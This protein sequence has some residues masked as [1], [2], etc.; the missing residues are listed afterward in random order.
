MS[1]S[2]NMLQLLSTLLMV[3]G[4]ITCAMSGIFNRSTIPMPQELLVRFMAMRDGTA[5]CIA[6]SLCSL[7]AR[8]NEPVGAMV[9]LRAVLTL[10]LVWL[11]TVWLDRIRI[12][13]Q[14]INF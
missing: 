4:L 10:V 12:I 11:L 5:L 2:P 7:A 6:G 1:Y 13:Q 14:R 3:A 8:M 9:V